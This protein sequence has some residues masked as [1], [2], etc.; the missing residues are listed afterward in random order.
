M[1]LYW[2]SLIIV[3]IGKELQEVGTEIFERDAGSSDG[4]PGGLDKTKFTMSFVLERGWK[5]EDVELVKSATSRHSRSLS[6]EQ[7]FLLG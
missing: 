5:K 3:G 7:C 1:S 6:A 4:A 2:T